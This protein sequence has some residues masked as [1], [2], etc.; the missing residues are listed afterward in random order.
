MLQTTM[1]SLSVESSSHWPSANTVHFVGTISNSSSV[2]TDS[3]WII[4]SGATNHI[5]SQLH[6][7]TN[8]VECNNW[9][10]LPNGAN[11]RVTHVG[12]A[13][14]PSGLQLQQVLCVP[15]LTYNLLSISKLLQHTNLIAHFSATSCYVQ[16]PLHHH[17]LE[18][19]SIHDGLYVFNTDVDFLIVC[20][21]VATI[22]AETWHARLG[23]V[24]CSILKQLDIKCTADF[25]DCDV[26][27]FAKQ[28]KLSFPNSKS[29]SA[30]CIDL[31]HAYL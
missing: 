29:T 15:G 17:V 30:E 25:Q 27:H 13:M 19:G 16:D 12:T 28:A 2:I 31:L 8:V 7:L 23:H 24:P 26:C 11:I 20:N 3:Q 21:Q 9:I 14:F 4:D 22:S 6:L 1:K 5:T 10:Q 18:I